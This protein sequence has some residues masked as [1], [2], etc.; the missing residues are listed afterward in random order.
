MNERGPTGL[1]TPAAL[2]S[3]AELLA[4]PAGVPGQAI[5]LASP[6]VAS[7]I[8]QNIPMQKLKSVQQNQSTEQK[9]EDQETIA[10]KAK[11]INKLDT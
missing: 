6:L 2:A 10:L 5:N 7:G 9:S 4:N 11:V 1:H 3:L 8:S